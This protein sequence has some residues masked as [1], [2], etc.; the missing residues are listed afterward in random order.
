MSSIYFNPRID[1]SFK[2]IFGSTKNA[3]ILIDFLNA[4]LYHGEARI[5]TVNILNPYMQGERYADKETYV[6]VRARLDDEREVLIEMQILN[7]GGFA[8]RV[9]YNAA[10]AYGNQLNRGSDY[11]SMHGVIGLTITDFKLFDEHDHWRSHFVL[12]ENHTGLRYPSDNN[13]ELVFVELPKFDIRQ[14]DLKRKE[15]CW[16]LFLKEG[17]MLDQATQAYLMSDPVI[18]RAYENLERAQLSGA[19]QYELECREIWLRDRITEKIYDRKI[20][21]AEGLA[22]GRIEGLS[23]GRTE[24]LSLGRI[25]GLSL[26]RTEGLM[27]AVLIQLDYKLGTLPQDVQD[28]IRQLKLPQ[29]EQLMKAL[30]GFIT[31]TDLQAWLDAANPNV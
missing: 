14:A 21:L 8:Q 19:E 22:K 26:G 12:R 31:L 23:L 10:K 24:G 17:E 5:K 20:A 1:F 4:V 29:I 7:V 25:E 27:Q 28:R 18:K 2:R 16:T 13:I 15:D 9:L 3:D 11:L 30:L 6:D